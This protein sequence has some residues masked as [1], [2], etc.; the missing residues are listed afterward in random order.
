QMES[1]MT[2]IKHAE[3]IKYALEKATYLFKNAEINVLD[4]L[5][6]IIALL[7]PLGQFGDNYRELASRIDSLAIEAKDIAEETEHQ[8]DEVS[9]DPEHASKLEARLDTINKLL[10]KHNVNDVHELIQM[11]ESYGQKINETT[12]LESRIEDLSKEVEELADTLKVQA[13]EISSVRKNAI[14][15]IKQEVLSLLKDLG[16]PGARFDIRQE[17]L[18]SLSQNGIDHLT[19]MFNANVGGELKPLSKIASGGELS[20]FMLSIKSMISQKK[21]LPTI[22]FD[23]ID[24][25]ISGETSTKVANILDRMSNNMQVITITHLPQ[26]A[27]R[28]QTH[29]LVYKSTVDDMTKTH[30]HLLDNQGR[31]AETAK[32]LGGEKPSKVMEETAKEL[33]FN[34]Q[35]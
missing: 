15:S 20:R 17:Y 29:M 14:P 3:E 2:I 27:S 12:S 30:V 9:Y 25:G 6:E 32:M 24:T 4:A 19:F 13:T 11:K 28:G 34:K 22:I 7:K 1:E 35:K 16:M 18:D 33:I 5:H 10:M 31:I 21:L 8:Q 23:E 26:I